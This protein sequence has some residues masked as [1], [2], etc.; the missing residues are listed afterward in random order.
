MS[1][2]S[3][4]QHCI[5]TEFRKNV[6]LML[7]A[8]KVRKF[9]VGPGKPGYPGMAVA[10]TAKWVAGNKVYNRITSNRFINLLKTQ[11][12]L[13]GTTERLNEF[14][15][16]LS[17]IYGWDPKY[18]YYRTCKPT[19]LNIHL[20]EFGKYYPELVEKVRVSAKPYTDGYLW[21]KQNFD[22]FVKSLGDWFPPLVAEFEAG[23]KAYQDNFKKKGVPS[24][25]WQLIQYLDG[26]TEYC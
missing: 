15:V 5:D 9:H 17:L 3:T 25:Q 26:S 24:Y 1:K 4:V 2:L 8:Q 20:K 12:F 19:N 13:V 6:T 7:V 22:K 16:I 21:A 23:L 18:L 10:M 14:L 11:Y